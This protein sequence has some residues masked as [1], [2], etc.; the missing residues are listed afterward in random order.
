MEAKTGTLVVKVL[1]AH[2]LN[3]EDLDGSSDPF[4]RIVVGDQEFMTE[5]KPHTV[6]PVWDETFEIKVCAVA[7]R[8]RSC[9]ASF[10]RWSGQLPQGQ[11][12][13]RMAD[14]H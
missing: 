6:N 3:A 4:V 11:A 10:A 12:C 1:R 9:C 8:V 14:N 7:R 2:N 5:T 13:I